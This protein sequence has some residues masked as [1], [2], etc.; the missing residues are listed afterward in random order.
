MKPSEIRAYNAA[1][2]PND[3]AYIVCQKAAP[4]GSLIER[5]VC[6]TRAE[7]DRLAALGNDDARLLVNDAQTRQFSIRQEPEFPANGHPK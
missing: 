3:P 1:L 5:K 7:W 2:A 6:R 4:V